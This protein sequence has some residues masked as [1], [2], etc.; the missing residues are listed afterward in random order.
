MIYTLLGS[1]FTE[2]FVNNWVEVIG[3][4]ASALVLISFLTSNQTKTRII[5]IVGCAIFVAYGIILPAWSTAFMNA[6]LIIVHI[7]FLSK[8]AIARKRSKNAGGTD[9]KK[10]AQPTADEI[11][12][13][14][15][16]AINDENAASE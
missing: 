4:S 10:P 13:K 12:V 8:D 6:A 5:N 2:F 14:E 9:G 3:I 1:A 16:S 11:A 15:E 7:V